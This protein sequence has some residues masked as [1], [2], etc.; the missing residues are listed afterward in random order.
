MEVGFGVG[1]EHGL[2]GCKPVRATFGITGPREV[3]LLC[4]RVPRGN[5]ALGHAGT[6]LGHAR[7][8]VIDCWS[9]GLLSCGGWLVKSGE[10][11]RLETV[12]RSLVN[13]IR[14]VGFIR[15]GS[16][17]L[18]DGRGESEESEKSKLFHSEILV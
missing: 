6:S 5:G 9:C 10:V 12:K 14:V 13:W 3:D 15:G 1:Y 7:L 17:L 11:D 2:S 8:V 16:G 4:S 18:S